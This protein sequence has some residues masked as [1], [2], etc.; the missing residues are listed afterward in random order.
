MIPYGAIHLGTYGAPM[1]IER[2]ALTDLTLRKLKSPSK[3]QLELYDTRTRGLSVRVG[4]TGTKTFFVAYRLKGERKK[5]RALLGRFGDISLSDAR[6]RAAKTLAQARDGIDP[7]ARITHEPAKFAFDKLIADFVERYVN[8]QNKRPQATQ[9][10][11]DRHFVTAWGDRDVRTLQWSDVEAVLSKVGRDSGEVEANRAFGRLRKFFNWLIQT[12]DSNDRLP[13]SPCDRQKP[14]FREQSRD[15]VLS[16]EELRRLWAASHVVGYPYGTIFQLWA[17]LGQRRSEV[18]NME[19]QQLDLDSSRWLLPARST[20]NSQPHLLPLPPLAVTILQ[21]CS[22]YISSPFVFP[23]GRSSGKAVCG[24][25]SMKGRLDRLSGVTGWTPHDL[26]RTQATRMA[27]ALKV[28]QN[29][30]D[31]IHNHKASGGS[32]VSRIYNRYGYLDEQTTALQDWSSYL[33]TRIIGPL[34][35]AGTAHE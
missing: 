1:A 16:D 5:R 20:K 3:G 11:L 30:I 25:T 33:S 8:R 35:L 2:A 27:E 7:A 15:R 31:L 23:G 17:I 24:F 22:R 14:L 34:V 28:P 12:S 9:R 19:W 13:F 10:I 29:V 18:A 32:Q 6:D 21:D 4:T 26:R